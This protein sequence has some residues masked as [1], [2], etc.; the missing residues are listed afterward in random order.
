MA[1]AA[2]SLRQGSVYPN[3][4]LRDTNKGWVREW[5]VVSNLAPC[6]SAH[7]GRVPEYKACW[8]EPPATEEMAQ[9]ERLLKEIADLSVQG[10]TGAVVTLSFYK[11]LTQPIQ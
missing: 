11:R 9:V 6:V 4:E 8:E 10:L 3:F 7:I 5:F 1:G 2:F